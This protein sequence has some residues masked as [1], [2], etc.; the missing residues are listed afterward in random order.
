MTRRI[1]DIELPRLRRVCPVHEKFCAFTGLEPGRCATCH[2]N[3]HDTE[4]HG[5]LPPHRIRPCLCAS[6]E[7]L[8]TAITSFDMHQ[9][10]AGVC[11]DP[12]RRGLVQVEQ[13][14]RYG[15]VWTLWA[16]PGER[17]EL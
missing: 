14:D 5:D 11:R 6:C 3:N 1:E 7:E 10:P 17:P 15:D 8:F 16:K 9:R 2:S 4:D 12:S 13:K